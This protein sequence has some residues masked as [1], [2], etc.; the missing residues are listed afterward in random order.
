[1][2]TWPET[3]LLNL[4]NIATAAGAERLPVPSVEA[5]YSYDFGFDIRPAAEMQLSGAYAAPSAGVAPTGGAGHRQPVGGRPKRALDVVIA[6]VAIALFLPLMIVVA[7]LVGLTGGAPIFSHRRLGFGGRSFPCYKFRTMVRDADRALAAHLAA[8]PEAAR[9]WEETRKLR[10]DPRVTAVGRLLRKTSLDELPQLFNILRGDM[11]CVGPRPITTEELERYG[12]FA[13]VYLASRPGLSGLWQVTGRSNTD[14][15]T[16]V[17][18]D[19]QYVRNWSLVS[20]LLILAR[21]PVAVLRTDE[22]C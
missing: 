8:D 22:V 1:M 15:P 18:L 11:S 10:H 12:D 19:N 20:D 6:S 13:G 21:T 2:A 3:M 7:A 4:G 5:P 16:R 9:E 17:S 14:F